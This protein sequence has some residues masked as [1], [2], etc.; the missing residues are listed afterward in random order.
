MEDFD[1]LAKFA[2]DPEYQK[3]GEDGSYMLPEGSPLLISIGERLAS[4]GLAEEAVAAYL[5]GQVTHTH[6]LARA[7]ARARTH[8]HTHMYTTGCEGS[9]R[10]LCAAEPVGQG[11]AAGRGT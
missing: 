4:V 9:N 3:R 6:M 8:T 5:R 10:L 11:R 7:R 1:R 2:T